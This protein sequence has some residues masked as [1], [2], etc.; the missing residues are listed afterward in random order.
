MAIFDCNRKLVCS[1]IG[2]FMLLEF[3]T[4]LKL[5]AGNIVEHRCISFNDL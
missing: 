3:V 4:V 2:T 5:E 1:E